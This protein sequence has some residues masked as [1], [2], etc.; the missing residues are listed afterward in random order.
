MSGQEHQLSLGIEHVAGCPYRFRCRTLSGPTLR[1]FPALQGT[2]TDAYVK[3]NAAGRYAI[4]DLEM[5]VGLL[6]VP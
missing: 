4:P 5:E 2:F 1:F 6:D 3:P